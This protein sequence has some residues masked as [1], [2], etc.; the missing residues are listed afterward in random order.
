MN[1][2][3]GMS[4]RSCSK[5]HIDSRIDNDLPRV[6]TNSTSDLRQCRIRDQASGIS[7]PKH[8]TPGMK[9]DDSVSLRSCHEGHT[10]SHVDDDLCK[11]LTNGISVLLS[12]GI[13]GQASGIS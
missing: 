5:G 3:D 13:R 1:Y 12:Y 11:P 4:P 8:D 10:D 6:L 7:E 2:D 9:R